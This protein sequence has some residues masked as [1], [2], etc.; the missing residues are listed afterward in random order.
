[1]ATDHIR[2]IL[3]ALIHIINKFML[4]ISKSHP[5]ITNVFIKF[6]KSYWHH[7]NQTCANCFIIHKP[8]SFISNLVNSNFD[9]AQG[10]TP[11]KTSPTFFAYGE[12]KEADQSSPG[13]PLGAQGL[14]GWS[15]RHEVRAWRRSEGE[16]T[17]F[18]L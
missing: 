8:T 7:K 10:S 16:R 18:A 12:K 14:G 4:V 9:L 17:S 13:G 11:D 5:S 3:N 2:N 15:G 1:M 6:Y